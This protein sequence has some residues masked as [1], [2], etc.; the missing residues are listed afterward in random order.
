M[1]GNINYEKYRT[2]NID[3]RFKIIDLFQPYA[4]R[5]LPLQRGEHTLHNIRAKMKNKRCP[6]SKGT[7]KT[8][9]F[10]W[11]SSENNEKY[12]TKNIN[13][14]FKIFRFLPLNPPAYRRQAKGDLKPSFRRVWEVE[15]KLR[16][17]QNKEHR[18]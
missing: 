8:K 18:L 15:R 12:E 2:K 3:Y 6:L 4:L 11:G 1:R 7:R 14:R 17:I 9:F 10:G 13:Y 5:A 16:K